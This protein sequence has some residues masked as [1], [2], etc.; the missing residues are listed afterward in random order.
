MPKKSQKLTPVLIS[1]RE[2]MLA[3]VTDTVGAKLDLAALQVEIEQ[4]KAE[5]DRQHQA[6]ID[7][8]TRQIQMNEGGLQVWASQHPEEFDGKK[9]IDL[10]AARFGFR[11]TPH[12]V[13][14]AKGVRNWDDVVARLLATLITENDEPNSPFRFIG[15]DYIRYGSPSVDKA[16]LLA[17]RENIPAEALKAA[18]IIFDQDEI[19]FFEPKSEV[20]EATKEAA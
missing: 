3:V 12:S 19:F 7:E 18:G 20:L 14:K 17:D 11:T 16:K 15:E 10:P 2:G 5:I 8:L 1:S 9:S 6:R 4:Q 13:E